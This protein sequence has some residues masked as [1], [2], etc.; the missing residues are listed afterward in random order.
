MNDRSRFDLREWCLGQQCDTHC[1]NG[2]EQDL[3]G[4]G[5]DSKNPSPA[6][7]S[8]EADGRNELGKQDKFE[9]ENGDSEAKTEILHGAI[10]PTEG[11]CMVLRR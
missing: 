1:S 3:N 8:K 7:E 9:H 10:E 5:D 4:K 6:T 11:K 2:H